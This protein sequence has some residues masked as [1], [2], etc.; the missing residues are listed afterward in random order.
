MLTK[1]FSEDVLMQ[2]P[3]FVA[4]KNQIGEYSFLN[5]TAA[6]WLGVDGKT[7]VSKGLKV[8]DMPCQI[9]EMS[10]VAEEQERQ[11]MSKRCKETILAYYGL[12]N[13]TWK[14]VVGTKSP[15][16]ND[17]DKVVGVVGQS[18][19]VSGNP[20]IDYMSILNRDASF[21]PRKQKQFSYKVEESFAD[22][23]LT[24]RQSEYLYH[25]LRLGSARQVAQITHRS[26][27]TIESQLATIK[28]Q[29]NCLSKADLIEFC[30]SSGL[31]QRIPQSILYNT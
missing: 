7:V 16:L 20:F 12:S 15:L 11:V 28:G 9:S 3:C 23:G 1:K 10:D 25:Y 27:R 5:K 14:L 29:L 26:I 19:D 4:I 18:T 21:L 6:K 8:S 2:L 31:Y 22:F 24:K 30:F 13:D 17:K